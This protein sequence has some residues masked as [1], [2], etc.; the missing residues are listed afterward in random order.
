MLLEE[1]KYDVVFETSQEK[2]V[3]SFLP[4]LS[5]EVFFLKN[6]FNESKNSK[7]GILNFGSYVG[8]AY[9]SVEVDGQMSLPIDIEIRSKKKLAMQMNTQP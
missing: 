2:I 7:V 6:L 9:L 5:R 8:R 3:T 4:K 1:T